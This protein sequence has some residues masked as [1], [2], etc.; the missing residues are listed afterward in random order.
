M[1][2]KIAAT[3]KILNVFSKWYSLWN[4]SFKSVCT[5]SR[6]NELNSQNQRAKEERQKIQQDL[7]TLN[8]FSSKLQVQLPALAYQ[9]DQ[10]TLNTFSSKLQ[11]QLPA[12]ACGDVATGE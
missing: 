1:L 10:D 4:C 6:N 5:I 7:D 9:Q 3:S 12:L 11:V 8:T 2:V